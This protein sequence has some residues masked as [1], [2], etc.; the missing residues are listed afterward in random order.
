LVSNYP[1][2]QQSPSTL[3]KDPQAIATTFVENTKNVLPGRKLQGKN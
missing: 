3:L 2:N 1:A